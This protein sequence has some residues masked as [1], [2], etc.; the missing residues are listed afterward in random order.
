MDSAVIPRSM[1][2]IRPMRCA[3]SLAAMIPR[4]QR[5]GPGSTP[6]WRTAV[7][8]QLGE[9]QTEDLKVPDSI[10]GDGRLFFCNFVQQN[11]KKKVLPGFEPGL[12]DS[13]SRVI[14]ITL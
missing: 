1:V 10:S 7:V 4:C 13:K 11:Y 5:G 12:L 6:G 3:I 2:R 9:R 8:A 14:T